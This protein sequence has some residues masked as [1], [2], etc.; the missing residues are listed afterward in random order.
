MTDPGRFIVFEGLDGSGTT[1]QVSRLAQRLTEVG[2]STEL[3][4]E[5]SNGPLGAVLR[6][7]IDGRVHLDPASMALAFAAD[8]TD[9]LF[10]EHNGVK[11]LINDG[12]WVLCDRYVLSSLA[13]QPTETV[14]QRWLEEVNAFAIEPDVTVF[15]DDDPAVCMERI[16][17]RSSTD[18]LFHDGDH[19]S[20]A[21][22]NYHRVITH[23]R[24]LGELLVVDANGSIDD[25]AL[26]VW[27][28][29]RTRLIQGEPPSVPEPS[30]VA[31]RPSRVA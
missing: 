27:D 22:R 14:D 15:L 7:V 25:V 3:T 28:G 17:A 12:H 9:H 23:G 5:P 24:V 26:S 4:K 11:K 18:E 31:D 30:V 6:Q 29:V 21:L 2:I 1:T 13:Y 20:R 19:L 16:S 10:N 8:R